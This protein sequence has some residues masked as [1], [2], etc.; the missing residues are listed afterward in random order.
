M[1]QEL[2]ACQKSKAL[3]LASGRSKAGSFPVSDGWF[4]SFPNGTS[5][6]IWICYDCLGLYMMI[7]WKKTKV[8]KKGDMKLDDLFFLP[9]FTS[10]LVFFSHWQLKVSKVD[11]VICFLVEANHGSTVGTGKHGCCRLA[12]VPSKK[13]G[14]KR[15]KLMAGMAERGWHSW[16]AA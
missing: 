6:W 2:I 10:K 5:G 13:R 4:G 11:L 16:M 1:H 9:F 3:E 14:C 12:L 15:Q 7:D 8:F